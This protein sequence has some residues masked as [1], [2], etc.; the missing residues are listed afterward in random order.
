MSLRLI[1]VRGVGSCRIRLIHLG[2]FYASTVI[3]VAEELLTRFDGH[4]RIFAGK[5]ASLSL[6]RA[7]SN[8]QMHLRF[9]HD[10]RAKTGVAPGFGHRHRTLPP[11]AAAIED[12]PV[13]VKIL[14]HLGLATR[15]P[16]RTPRVESIYSK[17]SKRDLLTLSLAFISLR[18]VS[19]DGP[20]CYC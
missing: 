7:C 18:S 1:R 8:L 19:A 12:S 5:N 14:S 3:A 9:M 20:K 13:I 17:H 10:P 11:T 16:P 2:I 4:N 6:P 15:A